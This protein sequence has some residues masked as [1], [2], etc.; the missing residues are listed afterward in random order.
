MSI[1][2]IQAK[3][4]DS[5]GAER[6]FQKALSLIQDQ[7]NIDLR[8]LPQQ[9]ANFFQE[10]AVGQAETGLRLPSLETIERIYALAAQTKDSQEKGFVLQH[11]A[12]AQANT[13]DFSAARRTIDS[14]P[15]DDIRQFSLQSLATIQSQKGD[16]N[17]ALETAANIHDPNLVPL[18]AQSIVQ[19]QTNSGDIIRAMETAAA[20]PADSARA[21]ALGA[22]AF[23]LA[24]DGRPEAD[25]V[26]HM[27]LET[28]R[29]AKDMP[30]P[31]H[32]FMSV[33]V[34]RALIEDFAGALEIVATLKPEDRPW[35][36]SNITEMMVLAGDLRSAV[37]VAENEATPL[38]RA[39]AFLGTA[40]GLLKQ[41]RK[42]REQSSK[43]K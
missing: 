23:Q 14:I 2:K 27:T 6:T 41:A 35:P 22:I 40:H 25:Q 33:A 16:Q 29:A 20:I 24:E 19:W 42:T 18:L 21:A 11:L 12:V 3:A 7:A 36:F 17:G 34:A 38:P 31:A 4:G 8:P 1:A 26:A 37:S 15:Y 30:V 9:L 43:Q 39:Y 13:G 28:A 32:V 5:V 10:V